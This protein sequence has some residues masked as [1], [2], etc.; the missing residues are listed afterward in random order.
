MVNVSLTRFQPNRDTLTR[1]WN[2]AV[3]IPGGRRLFSQLVGRAAPYTGTIGAQVEH[4]NQAMPGAVC[5]IA[6]EFVIICSRF[7]PLPWQI[8]SKRPQDSLWSQLSL[9]V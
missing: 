4:L 2:T 6:D 8:L 1:L 7:M 5:E 9:K 3:K